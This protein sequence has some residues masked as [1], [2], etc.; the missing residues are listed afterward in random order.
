MKIGLNCQS[1]L[2]NC[3]A[4]IGRYAYNL[5]KSLS[6]IDRQN[7]YSLYVRRKI[8]DPKRKIP[9]FAADNFYIQVDYLGRGPAGVL[10]GLDVYHATSPEV[11][12]VK[13]KKVVVTVHDVI[14]RAYPQGHTPQTIAEAE[15]QFQDILPKA[16]KIICVSRH[17]LN[18]L[19][20]FYP[21]NEKKMALVY[22]GV[23]KDIFYPLGEYELNPA[24]AAI[25]TRGIMDP[26][27]LFVGT[28]EPRKN[29]TGIVRAFHILKSRRK[30]SGKLVIIGMPGWMNAPV[31]D[32][33]EE[34]GLK[35]DILF[36]GYLSNADLCYFYNLAEVFVFPSFYEG[37]GFP[38]V[39]AFCCGAAV[40]TSNVSSCPEVAQDAALVVD[41]NDPEDIARAIDRI[42]VNKELKEHLKQK[43]LHRAL[44]FSFVNTAKNTLRVYWEGRVGE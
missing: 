36:P 14:H 9:Q 1:F 10:K 4:G 41:P 15:R 26:F 35:A 19:K 24:R 42:L 40:V 13:S 3:S 2:K 28:I 44:D 18:D 39:E 27:L 34:F 5:V 37:F 16:D 32:L 7:E 43:A 12:K 25:R 17:T 33:I 6:E 11:L 22:Q 38:I 20:R 29:L 8:F 23:D 31:F 21:I 30:F